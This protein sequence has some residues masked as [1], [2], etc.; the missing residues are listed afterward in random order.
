MAKVKW[1]NKEELFHIEKMKKRNR[2]KSM[3]KVKVKDDGKNKDL[4]KY[5]EV[6]DEN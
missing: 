5:Y 2:L 3:S 4:T 6:N 1:K